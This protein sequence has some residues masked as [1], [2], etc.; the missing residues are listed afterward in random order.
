MP[1]SITATRAPLRT[2]A[3]PHLFALYGALAISVLASEWIGNVSVPLGVTKVTLFPFLWAL[4]IGAAFSAMYHRQQRGAAAAIQTEQRA[5]R[6]VQIVI[7]LF[8]AKLGFIVADNLSKVIEAGWILFFQEIGNFVGTLLIAMPVALLLGIQRE[9]VGAT[10]SIGREAGVAIIA[11]RYGMNSA[12]GRGVLAEYI[13]GS[14]FGT[15]FIALFVSLV[16]SLGLFDPLALGMAAGIGSGSMTAA[17]VGALSSQF[18]DRAGEMQALA[19]ASNIITTVI[20]TYIMLFVSLPLANWLYARLRPW[21]YRARPA[22]DAPAA[23]SADDVADAI[24]DIREDE[25]PSL[26][27]VVSTLVIASAVALVGNQIAGKIPVLDALP[28]MAVVMAVT[29]AG[30]G[31]GRAFRRTHVPTLFWVSLVGIAVGYP[32]TA[33]AGALVPLVAKV[34]L[35]PLVTPVLALAGLALAKDF[36]VLRRLGWRIVVVSLLAN[37]GAFLASAVIAQAFL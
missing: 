18:P 37:A 7:L 20:G 14:V 31:L 19:A 2:A 29:L 24:A 12:E 17:A 27:A 35:L 6:M 26:G 13:T 8:V 16:A 25:I 23:S 36:P 4:L 15:L 32:G 22:Q 1:P 28:G 9:A 11:E 10:F 33:W 3:P 34:G 21:L 30:M 5:S